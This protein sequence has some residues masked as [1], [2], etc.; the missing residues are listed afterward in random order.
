M[1]SFKKKLIKNFELKD[2][3]SMKIGGKC[4]Y[5]LK[6]FSVDDVKNGIC[7]TKEKKIPYVILGN[8]TNVIFSDKKFNGLVISFSKKVGINDIKNDPNFFSKNNCFT[9]PSYLSLSLVIKYLVSEGYKGLENL[10]GI[11]GSLGGAVYM[12]AGAY[13]ACIKDCIHS[14]TYLDIKTNLIKTLKKNELNFSHRTSFFTNK[15]YLILSAT[16]KLNKDSKVNLS[17]TI[18]NIIKKRKHS[19]PLNYPSSGSFFKRPKNSYASF[20]IDKAGLKGKR[21][22]GVCVSNKHAGFIIN[23]SNGCFDDLMKLSSIIKKTVKAK[24]NVKLTEE[25]KIIK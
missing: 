6:T 18:E 15:K 5:F 19:Q 13:D 25:V 22:G 23:D 7:F 17:K 12:N 3:L 24:F 1:D 10:I 2:F 21:V 9:F 20:L 16:F 14:V 8:G 11:P 4:S